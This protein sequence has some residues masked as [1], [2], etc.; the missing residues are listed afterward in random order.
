MTRAAA[1]RLTWFIAA[2]GAVVSVAVTATQGAWAGASSAAGV[3][4]ALANWLA[5]KLLV[6]RLLGGSI[7]RQA[8]LAIVLIA[9]MGAFM[10]AIFFLLQ[11][12]WVQPIPFT[13]GVSTLM[14]GPLLGSLLHVLLT[15]KTESERTD[16]AR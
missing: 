2:L 3:A 11:R 8:G 12:G 14:A 16:A 5:L 13:L 10:G 7:Q 15:P 9:K 1:E 6:D 4:I